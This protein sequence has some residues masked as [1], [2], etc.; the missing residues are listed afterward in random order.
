MR[1]ILRT[2]VSATILAGVLA[3][4]TP[5]FSDAYL[6]SEESHV[7]SMV[8]ATRSK[9]GLGTL[10]MKSELVKMARGQAD[11]MAAKGDIFHNDSL[12][13][14]ITSYGL[15][16]KRV[17]E[18]VGMGPNVDLIEEAFLKSP[19]HYENIVH[20]TYDHA[21]I[22]VVDGK[23]GKRYVVQVFADLANTSSTAAP[24]KTAA[25]AASEPKKPVTTAPKAAPT[26]APEPATPA[27]APVA[28]P[29]PASRTPNAVLEGV[30]AHVAAY[31]S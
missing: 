23:D 12:G 11:K 13:A 22:G 29:R 20:S 30:V 9:K 17:G 21:G 19:H 18:N 16:W 7:L 27:P 15:D 25:K 14:D 10:K 3:L 6:P 5:A 1:N 26:V 4:G 24:I 2:A 8:N 28:T 31:P